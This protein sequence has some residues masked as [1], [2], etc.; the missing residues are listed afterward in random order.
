MLEKKMKKLRINWI[1]WLI[2]LVSLAYIIP[3]LFIGGIGKVTAS[4]LFWT[5]FAV[6]AILSTVKIISYWRDTDDS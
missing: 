2:F 6:A 3:Y 1:M 5:L 4:F